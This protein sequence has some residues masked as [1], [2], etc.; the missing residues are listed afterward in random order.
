MKTV[1]FCKIWKKKNDA[2]W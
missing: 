1:T 2:Y